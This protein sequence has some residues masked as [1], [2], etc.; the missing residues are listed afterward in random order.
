MGGLTTLDD[1]EF[2][3]QVI[4]NSLA[5]EIPN[6]NARISGSTQPVAVGG[7]G[8]AVDNIT[9]LQRVQVL[10]IIQVPKHDSSILTSGGAESTIRGYGDGVNVT[11]VADVVDIQSGGVGLQVPDLDHLVATGRNNQGAGSIGTEADS[12]NPLG[13]TQVA[14]AVATDGKVTLHLTTD[15]PQLDGLVAGAGNDKAVVGAERRR[16]DITGVTIEG[17]LGLTSGQIPQAHGLVPGAGQSKATILAKGNITDK[18][19]M[20]IEALLGDTKAFTVGG[21]VPDNSSLV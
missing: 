5:K 8:Q 11:S 12:G 16:H 2:G 17:G 20:T 13:V 7:E 1:G 3:A 21:Q 4:N 10:R 15:I 14:T 6:L 19:A 9:S 18:V